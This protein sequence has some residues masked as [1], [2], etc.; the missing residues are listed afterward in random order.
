MEHVIV[1]LFH[2]SRIHSCDVTIQADEMLTSSE[3]NYHILVSLVNKDYILLSFFVIQM[4]AEVKI[5]R[6]SAQRT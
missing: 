1:C 3:Q 2:A 4:I 5:A 6:C